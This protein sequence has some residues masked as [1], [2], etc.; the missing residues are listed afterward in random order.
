MVRTLR[1]I[2]LLRPTRG[3][4]RS[5]VDPRDEFACFDERLEA[6]GQGVEVGGR[7][8]AHDPMGEE[9][10]AP[11]EA[12]AGGAPI[13]RQMVAN[14]PPVGEGRIRAA[15]AQPDEPVDDPE[16]GGVTLRRVASS[17]AVT[18]HIA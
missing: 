6:T 16:M 7:H 18:R 12:A 11:F 8:F 14:E 9:V 10:R 13:G 15:R 1:V 2:L 17:P 3:G 5:G 4:A